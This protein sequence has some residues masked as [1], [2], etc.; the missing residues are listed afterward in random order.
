MAKNKQN[1][2]I[3]GVLFLGFLVTFFLDFTGLA[4]HQWL[5]ILIGSI[6]L[7]HLLIHW[8]WVLTVTKRLLANLQAEPAVLLDRLELIIELFNDRLLRIGDLDLVQY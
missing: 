2:L 1:W 8:K 4:W 6:A 7:Y 5:G 3:D